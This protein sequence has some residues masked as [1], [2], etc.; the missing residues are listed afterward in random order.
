[1]NSVSD[2]NDLGRVR[3]ELVT[4]SIGFVIIKKAEVEVGMCSEPRHD[5]V[6]SFS[7]RH[8]RVVAEGE[9][10]SMNDS[11]RFTHSSTHQGCSE[12]VGHLSLR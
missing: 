11:L 4:S 3:A 12:Y 6:D 5:G 10:H 1:M 8:A 2:S 9:N 7:H